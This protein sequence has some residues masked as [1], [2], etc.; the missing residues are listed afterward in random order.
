MKQWLHAARSLI[1]LGPALGGVCSAVVR[2]EDAGTSW[3]T[4]AVE[5]VDEEAEGVV[6]K[7]EDDAAIVATLAHCQSRCFTWGMLYTYPD[8]ATMMK[9]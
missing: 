3:D 1:G 4:T 8:S 9:I 2:G 6:V 5:A 7:M